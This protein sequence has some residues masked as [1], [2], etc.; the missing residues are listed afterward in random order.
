MRI[1]IRIIADIRRRYERGITRGRENGAISRAGF[2]DATDANGRLK[3]QQANELPRTEVDKS[4]ARAV[5]SDL[6]RAAGS[7]WKGDQGWT[8]LDDVSSSSL[9]RRSS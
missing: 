6:S 5:A 7:E 1:S 4:D 2:D 3:T 8:A 9:R